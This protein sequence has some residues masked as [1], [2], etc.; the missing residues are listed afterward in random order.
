M[1]KTE[2]DIRLFTRRGHDWSKRF[3]SLVKA[4]WFLPATHL[5]LHGEVIVPTEKGHSHFGALEADLGAGGSDRFVYF[6]FDIL[7]INSL[8]LRDCALIDRKSVL[9]ELLRGQGGPIKFS[10]HLAGGGSTLFRRA[11]ELS[12]R[13]WCRSASRPLTIQVVALT[14]QSAPAGLEQIIGPIE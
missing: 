3:S 8:S 7:H 4:A 13:D 11:C 14:G 10:E 9:A 1:H 6:A 5:I 2:N 12:L